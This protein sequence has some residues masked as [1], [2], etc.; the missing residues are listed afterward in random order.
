[1]VYEWRAEAENKMRASGRPGMS[2]EEVRDFCSR[3]MPSY[4]AYLPGLYETMERRQAL[5]EGGQGREHNSLGSEVEVGEVRV[6]EG[7]KEALVIE[8]GRDRNPVL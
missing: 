8:V 4:R 2:E 6:E 5:S 7:K 3:Y 1:M